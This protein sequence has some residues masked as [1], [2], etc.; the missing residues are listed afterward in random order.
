M[1]SGFVTIIG[2]PNVGKSTLLNRI[3]GEKLS[4]TSNKPQTT[5]NRIQLIYHEEDAQIIF[6]DTPGIQKPKNKLGNYMLGVSQDSLA[7]VDAITL[8]VDS[9]SRIGPTDKEILESLKKYKGKTDLILLINKIDQVEKGSLLPLIDQ[10]A[11]Y[12]LF[13]EIIPISAST[14]DNL[15]EYLQALK[16]ILPEGPKYFPDDYITDQPE[17]F[18]V[19]EFIREKALY[20]LQEEVPHGVMVVCDSMKEREDKDLLDIEATIY[21]ERDS[22]KGIIIGKKGQMLKTIGSQSRQD[23]ERFFSIKVNLQIWV[24]VSKNW[25]EK[26]N[27]VERFGY[28]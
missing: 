19:A 25:R 27:M 26:Q 24:K 20:N 21:V 1:K 4:I 16:R 15:E 22:H 2:R 11:K 10:Y 28:Q 9:S 7:E 13:K 18:I 6:L 5:R 3:M 14:G 12:N 8:M 23:L 17:K